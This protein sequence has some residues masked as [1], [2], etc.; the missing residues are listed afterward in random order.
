MTKTTHA[1][2][3]VAAEKIWWMYQNLLRAGD[4]YRQ[5]P[6]RNLKEAR[7]KNDDGMDSFK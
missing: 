4:K 7:V 5:A 2:S 3:F 1:S 6:L